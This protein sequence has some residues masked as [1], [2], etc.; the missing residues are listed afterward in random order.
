MAIL[1]DHDVLEDCTVE[2]MNGNGASFG[3]EG[4]V[5]HIPAGTGR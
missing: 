2:Q 3:G 4:L 1:G 5:V